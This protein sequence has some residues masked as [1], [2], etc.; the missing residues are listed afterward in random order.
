MSLASFFLWH[1]SE[2]ARRLGMFMADRARRR[3]ARERRD[4]VWR[5]VHEA[6]RD[7]RW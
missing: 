6:E 7:R 2:V 1:R 4:G 5:F 3:I